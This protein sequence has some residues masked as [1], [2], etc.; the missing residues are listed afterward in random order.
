MK[1]LNKHIARLASSLGPDFTEVLRVTADAFVLRAIGAGLAFALNV[2]VSRL[3]GAEGAGLY[4]LA[5]SVVS[6][7]A[8]VS[9][10]GFDNALLRFIVTA[11]IKGHGNALVGVFRLS[12]SIAALASLG[13]V[14]LVLLSAP[15]LASRVF[16]EPALAPVLGLMSMGIFTLALM[17]LLSECLKGLNWVRNSMLVSGVIYPAVALVVIWSLADYGAS[18]AALAYVLGTGVAAAFGWLMWKVGTR[19]VSASEPAFEC[20]V[21][22]RSSRPL[23]AMAL[24]NQGILPWVPLFLLGV[25]GTTEEAGIFGAATRVAMLITFFLTAVNMVIAPKF[26]ELHAKGEMI[27]LGRLARNFALLATVV[28]SPP[29]LALVFA[30]DWVMALFGQEFSRGDHVLAILAVGQFINVA[31]GSVGYLLMMTGHEKDMRNGSI[32]A[33]IVLFSISLSAIYYSPMIAL[34]CAS[35]A[36]L[37]TLN[38]YAAFQ[39]WNR[40]GICLLRGLKGKT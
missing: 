33:M 5:L 24:I 29:L 21:L 40:L 36:S 34:A 27:A 14:A 26:A 37:A 30:G 7:S 11:R 8:V 10:L 18:G 25:L 35:A 39:V 31:T 22:L 19:S 32:L 28:A 17:S 1:R 3:L 6:I 9:K 23:W 20:A 38:L 12:M 2:A 15:W 16:S 4:F 13:A